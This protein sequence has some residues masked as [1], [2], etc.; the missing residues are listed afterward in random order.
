[1]ATARARDQLQAIAVA[2]G[3]DVLGKTPV[4]RLKSVVGRVLWT[5]CNFFRL[6]H[7]GKHGGRNGDASR[8]LG[9]SLPPRSIDFA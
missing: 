6:L 9:Q 2:E 8:L 5:S 4:E 1:M 3:V 7:T